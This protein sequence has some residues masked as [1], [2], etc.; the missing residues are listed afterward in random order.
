VSRKFLV[1][2]AALFATAACEGSPHGF[3]AGPTGPTPAGVGP[4]I[5]SVAAASVA[6]SAAT[7]R[8]ITDADSDSHVEFG[9]TETYGSV[10]SADGFVKDHTVAISGLKPGTPYHFRVRSVDQAGTLAVSGNHTFKTPDEGGAA[11]DRAGEA[12]SPGGDGRP[13]VSI[14]SPSPRDSLSGTVSVTAAADDD[15]GV[16][17]VQFRLDGADL[18]RAD[19]RK[20]FSVRWDT[21]DARDGSHSLTAIARDT[22]GNT[23]TSETV[24]VSV[25]NSSS[26]DGGGGGSSPDPDSPTAPAPSPSP[27]PPP[28]SGSNSSWPNEPDGFRTRNDQS[29]DAVTGNGWSYRR[30]QSSKNDDIVSDSGAPESARNVL[31]IIFTPDMD[32]DS[33][34]SVHW[35]TFGTNR[36]REIFTGWWMKLSPNWKPSPAGGGKIAFLWPPDGEGQVYANIGGSGAPHRININT[37]WAPYGQKFWEPNVRTTSVSYDRWY[38]VEWYLRWESSPGAGDGIIR[39]W[40]NGSLNGDYR[41]VRFPDCCL[42]QFE[43]APTL[44]NPPSSEQYMYIDHTYVSTP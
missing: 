35:M 4:S 17:S 31:R 27:A 36:P 21:R 25:K 14:T 19:D 3:L 15:Q 42:Q 18:G 26:T 43:F 28:T 37:E 16:A 1:C 22:A 34:P 2:L 44:Q 20:P 39:W 12:G 38:R 40:V 9:P 6:P 5:S 13:S 8:W 29:W 41:N 11:A 23:T 10:T 32:R 33:E 7:I 30:R 24:T